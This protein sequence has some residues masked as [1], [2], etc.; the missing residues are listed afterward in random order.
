MAAGRGAAALRRAWR[1][2]RA[3]LLEPSYTPLVAACL[4]LAEGGVNLWVIRRVPCECRGTAWPG[5]ARRRGAAGRGGGGGAGAGPGQRGQL[6]PGLGTPPGAAAGGTV[7]LAGP[8]GPPPARLGVSSPRPGQRGGTG[9][10]GW[11]GG[12]RGAS[13]GGRAGAGGGGWPFQQCPPHLTRPRA[14]PADT[15]IDWQAYMEEVEGF[16]NGTLD[17]TQL[18]GD[19]GPLV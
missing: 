18:K 4:C 2:R 8:A 16:A 19:T 1:E 10:P 17:Y 13:A 15:E 11:G 14:R 5:P 7:P 6:V 9:G 3:L 12:G